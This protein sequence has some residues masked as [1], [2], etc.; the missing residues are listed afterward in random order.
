MTFSLHQ[1]CIKPVKQLNGPEKLTDTRS[2]SVYIPPCPFHQLSMCLARQKF[3]STCL[4][5]I[6]K[7]HPPHQLDPH[8]CTNCNRCRSIS[9]IAFHAGKSCAPFYSCFHSHTEKG[10]CIT[11]A[12]SVLIMLQS[13]A[14]VQEVLES[15]PAVGSPRHK[16]PVLSITSQSQALLMVMLSSLNEPVGLQQVL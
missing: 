1:T 3:I 11:S 4:D 16:V 13:H 5:L 15:N 2:A 7:C 6:T 8:L 9:M 10:G 14:E 12:K